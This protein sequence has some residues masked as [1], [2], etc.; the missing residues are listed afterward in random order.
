MR[1][2]LGE[3]EYIVMLCV[4]RLQPHDSYG[5]EI[6]RELER[7]GKRPTSLANVYVALKRLQRKNLA[8][9]KMCKPYARGRPRSVFK[10]TA[11]GERTMRQAYQARR[12][13]E[14]G[15]FDE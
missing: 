3:L 10:L 11:L 13:M 7:R 4:K 14:E 9:T 1:Q 8:V 5:M 6:R 15:I 12:L 2:H